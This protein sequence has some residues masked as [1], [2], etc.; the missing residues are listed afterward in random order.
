MKCCQAEV[1]KYT[2]QMVEES[3]RQL[4]EEKT[5][6]EK[7]YFGLDGTPSC[8]FYLKGVEVLLIGE[9]WDLPF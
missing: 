9:N 7:W 4:A 5:G 1:H 6:T 8:N 3:S 2:S